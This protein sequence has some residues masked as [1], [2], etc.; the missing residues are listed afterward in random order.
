MKKNDLPRRISFFDDV[1]KNS[2][3]FCITIYNGFYNISADGEAFHFDNEGLTKEK[4]LEYFSFIF[5]YHSKNWENL[6][7]EKLA[8][9]VSKKFPLNDLMFKDEE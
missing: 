6:D 8:N 4:A 9:I 5:D 7:A 3:V 2:L 1:S